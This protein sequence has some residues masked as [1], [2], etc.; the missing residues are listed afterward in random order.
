[1]GNPD[2]VSTQCIINER[3]S[4]VV[5]WKFLPRLRKKGVKTEIRKELYHCAGCT[6][7]I[8]GA[9]CFQYAQEVGEPLTCDRVH[10]TYFVKKESLECPVVQK[11]TLE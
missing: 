1:M 8:P 3:D 6:A 11:E 5:D 4:I 9:L 2:P 7:V 10:S